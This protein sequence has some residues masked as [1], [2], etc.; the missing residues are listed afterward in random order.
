MLGLLLAQAARTKRLVRRA[1]EVKG[2]PLVD[3]AL[4]RIGAAPGDLAIAETDELRGPALC[5]L[6]QPTILLPKGWTER[7]SAAEMHCVLLHEVGHLR[8]RDIFWRW[9]FLLARAVHWFNPLVWV[10]ERAFRLNQEMACDEWVLRQ[11]RAAS[12]QDYGEVLL[13]ASG[14]SVRSGLT[15]PLHAGMAES[16][17][18]LP[19]RIRHLTRIRPWGWGAVAL[20]IIAGAGLVILCGP[21]REERKVEIVHVLKVPAPKAK[22]T[23]SAQAAEPAPEQKQKVPRFVTIQPRFLELSAKAVEEILGEADTLPGM[24]FKGVFSNDKF[25]SMLRK[26]NQMKGV[27]LIS[28]PKV[29]TA[30]GR[31]AVIGV[32]SDYRIPA[33]TPPSGSAPSFT[34]DESGLGGLSLFLEAEAHVGAENQMMD[35]TMAV[36]V[37]KEQERRTATAPVFY[38]L[39]N[40]SQLTM[41][42]GDTAVFSGPVPS[43]AGKATEGRRLVVFVTMSILSEEE[44]RAQVAASQAAGAKS[45][46]AAPAAGDMAYG[47]PVP[48]KPG[49]ITSPYAPDKG[50]VD[51]RGFPPGTEVKCPYTNKLFRVP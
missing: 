50:Y 4:A 10:A 17:S 11:G 30:S 18:G 7:L 23:V 9:V 16:H 5:G 47:E 41:G 48:G 2:R 6:S 43:E 39:D 44:S 32:G 49:F 36:R 28:A 15:S 21:G 14:F 19:Q 51:V 40:T 42:S 29:T 3:E 45:P 1:S 22:P 12:V 20:V 26:L 13:M 24:N 27:D 34:P 25:Q 31:K 35:L 46:A 37:T 38:L 8:R 33:D